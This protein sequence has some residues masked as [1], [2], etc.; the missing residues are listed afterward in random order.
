MFTIALVEYLRRSSNTSLD[1]LV[2]LG[3][4][5]S[6]WPA[7]L[8][9]VPESPARD[10]LLLRAYERE[11]DPARAF[12]DTLLDEIARALRNAGIAREV[13][14][15]LIT[16]AQSV[17]EQRAFLDVLDK[18]LAPEAGG[19]ATH[20]DS[21]HV[22]VT[23]GLRHHPILVL[24]A[25]LALE[26][27]HGVRIDGVYYGAFELRRGGTVTPVVE[28]HGALELARLQQAAALYQHA[29]TLRPLLDAIDE[30]EHDLK[31]AFDDLVHG[32]ETHNYRL[33]FEAAKATRAA[34][35]KGSFDPARRK[36]LESVLGA[37]ARPELAQSQFAQARA[38]LDRN[39]LLRCALEIYEG[40]ISQACARLGQS[41]RLFPDREVGCRE[42]DARLS[43][44]CGWPDAKALRNAM[45]HGSEPTYERVR[46]VLANS[47]ELR[48]KLR[49]LIE[50][51]PKAIDAAFP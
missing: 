34:L 38:S 44:D 42:L 18:A 5:A 47:T 40:A 10:D 27:T 43:R 28:L 37:L 35:E 41:D 45:A 14:C 36:V 25:L 15:S 29:G 49:S 46:A 2:V 20:S 12:D 33:M 8:E 1:R 21:V 19:G 9:I 48:K 22:D 31:R 23:H 4:A 51:L 17:D 32:W 16:E 6:V 13:R 50:R 7:L 3:T 26:Q 24:Q 39:D 30:R 11:E